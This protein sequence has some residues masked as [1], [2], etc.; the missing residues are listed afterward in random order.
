MVVRKVLKQRPIE[1]LQQ[2]SSANSC[3]WTL[4][5]ME[6]PYTAKTTP[7]SYSASKLY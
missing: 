1:M 6:D 5:V 4:I 2:R 7:W 3:M